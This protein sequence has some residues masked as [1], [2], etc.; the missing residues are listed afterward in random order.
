MKPRET[1][2]PAAPPPPP[3]SKR[4]P[5]KRYLST[6]ELQVFPVGG[7]ESTSGDG[8]TWEAPKKNI[9]DDE[10][11]RSQTVKPGRKP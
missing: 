9:E 3:P 10:A 6:P 8:K 7:T 4:A 5:S 1:I 11:R 2:L